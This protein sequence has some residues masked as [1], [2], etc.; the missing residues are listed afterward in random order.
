MAH[1]LI[2]H[3]LPQTVADTLQAAGHTVAQE[4]FTKP[5][6]QEALIATLARAQYDAVITLLTDKITPAV[7]DAAPSVKLWANYATGYDNIDVAAATARGMMVTNAPAVESA[8]AVAEHTIAL[9][10][11]LSRNVVAADTYTKAGKYEGWDPMLF[12][13]TNFF[14][15]TIGIIGAGKIGRRV[16]YYARALGLS[17]VYHDINHD[18]ELEETLGATFLPSNEDVLKQADFISLHVP[19]LESTRHLINAERLNLMKPTAYLVN[20]ARGAVVDEDALVSALTEKRIAGAA[21]D[22]YEH[23]PQMSEQLRALDTVILTPH[24]ASASVEARA[25]MCDVVLKNVLAFT[26]GQ[27]LPNQ[28]K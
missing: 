27:P 11:A 1:I 25:E 14:K 19:L 18:K 12:I 3:T 2:T 23:E 5:P 7:M 16:A 24:I 15:K 28:V 13:G 17:V 4:T 22:V 21:L 9:L 6:T 26:A 20:T 8:E 10:F